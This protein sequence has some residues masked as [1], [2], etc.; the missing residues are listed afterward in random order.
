[1]LVMAFALVS[2]ENIFH[3]DSLDFMWRLDKVEF[4]DGIDLYGNAC[5]EQLKEGLWISFARDLVEIDNNNSY[6]STV[7]LQTEY[8]DSIRFDFSMCTNETTL[9]AELR[10][11]G[12]PSRV[13]AFYKTCLDKKKM[14]L[15]GDRTTLYFTKW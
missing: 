6:F 12:I 5:K 10:Q 3:N 8:G 11:F 4:P 9:D 13:T 1:M 15:K 2:C 7:G 14:I